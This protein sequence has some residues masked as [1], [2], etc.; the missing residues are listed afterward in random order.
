MASDG[1]RFVL[2]SLFFLSYWQRNLCSA[3]LEEGGQGSDATEKAVKVTNF[4]IRIK[5][6][7]IEEFEKNKFI[8]AMA[9]SAKVPVENVEVDN[10]RF[11]I[12]AAYEFSTSPLPSEAQVSAAVA[13]LTLVDGANIT[14]AAKEDSIVEV[15]IEVPVSRKK[16]AIALT[17]SLKDVAGL[18]SRL[19]AALG[20]SVA[21]PRWMAREI[22]VAAAARLL[23]V[24]RSST[25][26]SGNKR[27]GAARGGEEL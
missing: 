26:A 16:K 18:A 11:V 8:A 4:N 10:L 21:A 3:S 2:A 13:A 20:T 27:R 7:R 24:G 23:G 1:R 12:Q 15:E 5:V 17:H 22:A 14:S 25:P 19:S 9:T 6:N